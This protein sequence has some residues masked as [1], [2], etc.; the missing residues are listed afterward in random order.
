MARVTSKPRDA[1]HQ[2]RTM[3][4]EIRT[5]ATPEQAWR[6]WADPSKIPQWFA[7][8]ARGEAKVGETMTWIFEK[9]G[10]EIPY[11]VVAV[12]ENKQFALGGQLPGRPPFLLEVIIERDAG[13]TVIRIVNSGFLHGGSW[14]DEYEGVASG[15]EMSL[16]LLK[17]Y[18]EHHY[19]EPKRTFLVLQPAS[20][21]ADAVRQWFIEPARLT[22]WLARG[23]AALEAP[24]TV[25]ARVR[26]PLAEGSVIEGH[27]LAITR[28]EVAMSWP[29][30]RCVVELKAFKLGP[31]QMI[32][33]RGTTWGTAPERVSQIERECGVALEGLARAL[34]GQAR[35]LAKGG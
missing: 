8:A 35:S 9:F 18:L 2:G 23:G 15:W 1:R 11:Q 6:A 19:G 24:D 30:E 26:L 27:T 21:D 5:S 22:Q 14:D 12:D 4:F 13:E 10:Y 34:G 3:E 31:Q 32:G 16:G 20:Y 25:G 29:S 33:I 17:Y 7:D 28:S